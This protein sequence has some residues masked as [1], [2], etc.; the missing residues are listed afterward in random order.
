MKFRLRNLGL[1]AGRPVAFIHT[2]RARELNL[3]VGDRVE[4]SCR[5]KKIIA[6]VDVIKSAIK[7]GEISLSEEATDYLGA[8]QREIVD[9]SLALE[10]KSTAFILKKLIGRTLSKKEIYSIIK[11]IVDNALTEA[12]VAYFVSGVY[13]NGMS[14]EETIYLTEAIYK[15]GKIINWGSKYAVDKHSIGGI[16]GNRTT[17][18]VVSICAAAGLIMPKTSSRAITSAAGTADVIETIANVNLSIPLLKKTV[19][20]TNACLAWGGSLGMAPADD[21]LIRVERLL[22]LDPESQL[23]ASIMAKKLAVGSKYV[24]IDIPYGK[25]A[26]VSFDEAK[27]LRSKFEKVAK[28]FRLKLKVVLTDGSQPIGNGIGPV[29]EMKDVLKVLRRDNPPI[30]LEKKS[31]FLAGE[32]LEM[33]GEIGKGRGQNLAL[34]ILN[35]GKANK[36]FE[37]I[38]KFQGRKNGS[39]KSAKFSHTI[40]AKSSG[41]IRSISNKSINYLSRILGCPADKSA[42]IYLYKHNSEKIFKSEPIAVLY[43]ESKEKLKDGLNYFYNSKPILIK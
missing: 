6:I 4:I 1:H 14:L 8:K 40:K 28:H 10:P 11:D 42:G 24:L 13:E 7:S 20:K 36:K 29:L 23:I 21:K 5:K 27:K 31:I 19:S 12:E 26:K 16:A 32:I 38:I 35:S 9:V 18:I 15:T 22:S 34:E 17:P 30:D 37:E 41:K 2:D 25:E 39:L 43:S 33:T 3:H